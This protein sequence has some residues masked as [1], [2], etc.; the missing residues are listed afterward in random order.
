MLRVAPREATLRQALVL[1]DRSQSLS[2]SSG[3]ADRASARFDA[4]RS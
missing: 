3:D 4:H 1:E 2:V